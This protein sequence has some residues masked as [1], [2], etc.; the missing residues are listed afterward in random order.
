MKPEEAE[1]YDKS[2]FEKLMNMKIFDT[3]YDETAADFIDKL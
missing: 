3:Q 1:Q 2:L